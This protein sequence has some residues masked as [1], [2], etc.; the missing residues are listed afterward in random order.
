MMHDEGR[1]RSG[2]K[3][4]IS[5]CVGNIA[6]RDPGDGAWIVNEKTPSARWRSPRPVGMQGEYDDT[7]F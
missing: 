7:V 4:W 2:R 5:Q 6:F 1:P 3:L